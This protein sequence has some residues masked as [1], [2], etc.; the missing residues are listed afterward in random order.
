MSEELTKGY[1]IPWNWS[2]RQFRAFMKVLAV[3]LGPLEDQ[4]GL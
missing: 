3:N 1:R 4:P 2:Y